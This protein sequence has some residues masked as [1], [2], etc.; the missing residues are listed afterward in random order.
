[1]HA[2][3]RLIGKQVTVHYYD[4]QFVVS[5]NDSTPVPP[6]RNNDIMPDDTSSLIYTSGT[7]GLPKGTVFR[8]GRELVVGH[9]VAA[10]LRLKPTDR[11]Y[12]CMPLY[13]GA[14]HGLCVTPLIHAGASLA[15]GRKFSHKT[16]WSEARASNA[17]IVQYVGE[18]CR[19]LLNGPPSPLDREHNV[20][21]AWG[22]GMRPD[23]WEPFRQRFGIPCINELY[24]ATDGMGGT[25]NENRGEFS[26]YSVGVRGLIWRLT[27][28]KNERI[29]KI[30][31]DLETLVRDRNGFVVQCATDE[32]GEV[33]HQLDPADPDAG[34]ARYYGND[35]A[36]EKR[37]IRDVFE[38]GDMYVF[39]H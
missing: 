12:T 11:M 3:L 35:S 19:Y 14:A 20:R 24:A 28:G 27:N 15:L 34:V 4:P 36:T 8:R 6:T 13:H 21:M 7:T 5:L 25:F 1:M 17:N 30:D 33:L 22:N 18:L 31:E 16:F 23:V 10:Y 2:R 9:S 32:P 26:R 37:R 39:F 29:V 38:K